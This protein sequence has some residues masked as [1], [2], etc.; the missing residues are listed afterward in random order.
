MHLAR[1]VGVYFF[2]ARAESYRSKDQK[3][4]QAYRN[5]HSLPHNPSYSP[6]YGS[7]LHWQEVLS[8]QQYNA[9]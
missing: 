9:A 4:K 7:R 3:P 6:T 8:Q 5:A 1:V 2:G